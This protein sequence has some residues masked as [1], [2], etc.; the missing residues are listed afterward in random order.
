MTRL[1]IFIGTLLFA[2]LPPAAFCANPFSGRYVAKSQAGE[3][4]LDLRP[5]GAGA[6]R[7]TLVLPNGNSARLTAMAEGNQ[8]SGVLEDGKESLRFAAHANGEQLL[9][10]VGGL[11]LSFTRQQGLQDVND[12]SLGFRFHTPD[13]FSALPGKIWYQL[14]SPQTEAR[15]LVMRH[16]AGS[17]QEMKKLSA[18]GITYGQE[19]Q[20]MPAGPATMLTPSTM[21]LDLTGQIEGRPGKA[22]LVVLQSPHGGGAMILAGGS[23]GALREYT[24]LA[25]AIAKTVQFQKFDVTPAMDFWTTRLKGKKLHYFSRYSSAG[26]SGG[27][28]EHKQMSLC[29]DGSFHS[30]GD[31]SGSIDVPGASASMGRNSGNAGKWKLAPNLDQV[32]LV[33]LFANGAEGRI[34]LTDQGGKTFLNG[35][36]WLLEP[37]QDC[38]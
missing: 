28:A 22:R 19:I 35:Q 25:D 12:A 11:E 33:L 13:G 1:H 15:I 36:R 23:E 3:S 31:F 32:M 8:M 5:A 4:I 7:G 20:L 16:T 2:L 37:A 34:T 14:I 30:Q 29:A 6:V 26:S 17:I 21:A 24:T 18:E 38:R 9:L 27:Y 10:S